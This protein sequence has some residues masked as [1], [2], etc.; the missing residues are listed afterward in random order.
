M[1]L[2]LKK[3]LL[4]GT[5]IVA[6]GAAPFVIT[7]AYAAE[8]SVD[9]DDSGTFDADEL[10]VS[11][12]D[13]GAVTNG[14]GAASEATDSHDV[15]VNADATI[16]VQSG[17]Q[18]G[19]GD[20]GV[21][22]VVAGAD[23]LTL[24]I[25][26][27]V[28]D[29]GAEAVT[30]AGDV[31]VGAFTSLNLAITG[32][33]TDGVA[34][35][36]SV[37]LNGAINLGTGAFTIT[38]DAGNAGNNVDV[39]VSGNITAGS[40]VLN[41]ANSTATL[42]LDGGTVQTIS[43]TVDGGGAGEGIIK[44]GNTAGVTFVGDIGT[45]NF[46]VDS[47]N[48]GVDGSSTVTAT[49]QG[50]V[51]TAN[52]IV[53]GDLDA[54]AT[55]DAVTVTFDTTGGAQAVTGA[56]DSNGTDSANVIVSGGSVLTANDNWG[57]VNAFNS[58]TLSGSGTGLTHAGALRATTVTV[59]AGTTLTSSGDIT[60]TA[61]NFTGAGTVALQNGIT[62]NGDVDNTS[63]TAGVG[64]LTGTGAGT[65]TVT[66]N[67]GATNSLGT[68][69]HD[70]TGTFQF[71]GTVAATTI[72]TS[73]TTTYDF[74]DSVVANFNFGGDGAI[75]LADGANFTGAINNTSGADGAGNL[76]LESAGGNTS[77]IS[78]A[79]GATNTLNTISI[80]GTGTSAFGSTVAVDDIDFTAAGT[81]NFAG[82]VT[83]T[84]DID[85]ANNAGTINFADNADL[86]GSIDSTGGANGTVNF[87]GTSSV[88]GTIGITTNE[89]AAI[90]FNGGA[91]ETVTLADN[92]AATDIKIAG[93]GT[94]QANGNIT[95]AVDFDADGV[96]RLADG[97]DI[98]GAIITSTLGEGSLILQGNADIDA[99]GTDGTELKAFTVLGTG[100]TVGLAGNFE[101]ANTTNIDGNIVNATG[102]FDADTGQVLNFDVTGATAAGQI[103]AGGA[104][105][106]AADAV[107][108]IDVSTGDAIAD[109]QSFVLVD[110][111]GGAGIAD[112]TTTITDNSFLVSFAQ[113]TTNDEDLVVTAT[114]STTASAGTTTNNTAVGAVLDG[115]G[116]SG[117]TQLALIQQ[118][119]AAASTQKA[120]NDILESTQPTVDAG[121]VA[122]VVSV[123]NQSLN[124]LGTRLASL[125]DGSEGTGMYAGNGM[126]GTKVWAQAFGN[127]M[128][129]DARDGID[130]YD[131]STL[132]LAFGIDTAD[133]LEGMTL[134]FAGSYANTD[135][136]SD[137]VN[138][139][140]TEISSWQVAA[141]A[142]YDLS[143]T[144]FLDVIIGYA[145]NDI[146]SNR[147]NVGGIS[148]LTAK[149]DRD[150]TQYFA[151]AE[152]GNAY[153]LDAM[154]GVTLTPSALL[155]YIHV[156]Q[157]GYTETGA[158][159]A[160][161][162][163]NPDDM[164]I[165]ELG[166]S[167]EASWK[168]RLASGGWLKPAAHIGYRHDV[169]GD[170]AAATSSF[171]GGGATF[172]TEG[173]DPATSTFNAGFG[174]TVYDTN[175]WE[176]TGG[177]DFEYKSDYSAHSGVV[178]AT[179][180]F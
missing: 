42:V 41:G 81:I 141:Y 32:E 123:T 94:V 67:V 171:L 128:E 17:D 58:V 53:I 97:G 37:D 47:I 26:D 49:F 44:V 118:N 129:Q 10:A 15:R 55:V 147:Y 14:A 40:T 146:E 136:D 86:T 73:S 39:S 31:S 74:A 54:A 34:D 52:G 173:F 124:V 178:K 80:D 179:Y 155:N 22:A 109:G 100:S 79:I 143:N 150:G 127:T 29:N 30:I 63:G 13:W 112:L 35:T 69:S 92:V 7:P 116:T 61:V 89:L 64:T 133:R 62:I 106:I 8:L 108:S 169:V 95:G 138:A 4:A 91:G 85:F 114:V 158:G 16:T 103:T 115:I 56:V 75:E 51:A 122:S 164:D 5:A 1:T 105:T 12:F 43:G 33:D 99:F 84:N 120:V 153:M 145:Y 45:T 139:T 77:T 113:D 6:V 135:V 28:N 170:D 142:D 167:L 65:N 152:I 119:I 46:T 88:S 161:L 48:I 111:T 168:K 104:A 134:G 130:G 82:D 90:N 21:A 140:E 59:G 60:A 71:N 93:V 76:S 132:G 78:G 157:D 25:D 156:D 38:A 159:G 18:I 162:V 68:I 165:L 83:T 20:T 175:N 70:G 50:D 3:L 96:L 163:V 121:S 101:A 131:A 110:G 144:A 87:A 102:T 149:G 174:A 172:K 176:F 9:A 151:R 166:L 126:Y 24:T 19:D 36:L 66:G 27:N 98:T 117:N 72:S 107:L 2:N 125:R 160:N 137:N 11:P 177:Y 154:N 180:K 57:A 148:G 23:A